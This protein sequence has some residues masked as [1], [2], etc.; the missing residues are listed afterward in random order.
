[1]NWDW[2]WDQNEGHEE[3]NALVDLGIAF[4]ALLVIINDMYML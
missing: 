3:L 2:D 4:L 1:M